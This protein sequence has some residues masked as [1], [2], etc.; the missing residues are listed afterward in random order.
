[1]TIQEIEQGLVQRIATITNRAAGDIDPAKP[2]HEL[3][4]D[5]LGFVEVLIYIEKNLKLQLIASQLN[6]KDFESVRTLATYVHS[7]LSDAQ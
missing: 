5:S 6:R 1:M 2:F 3:G 7:K 4:I